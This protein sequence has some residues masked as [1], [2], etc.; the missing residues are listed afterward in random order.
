MTN[1]LNS[2]DTIYMVKPDSYAAECLDNQGKHHQIQQEAIA[3]Y[4]ELLNLDSTENLVGVMPYDFSAVV[5]DGETYAFEAA[6]KKAQ[7]GFRGFRKNSPLFKKLEEARKGLVSKD[8]YSPFTLFDVFG[9]VPTGQFG[10]SRRNLTGSHRF[11]GD[12]VGENYYFVS[13]SDLEAIPE[14]TRPD[15]DPITFDEYYQAVR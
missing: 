11:T 4:T 14:E 15:L 6:L 3:I 5:V 7:D 8:H 12:N 13:V 10:Q 2:R 9:R 1:L